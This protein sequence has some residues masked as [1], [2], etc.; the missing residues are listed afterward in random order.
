MPRRLVAV[1]VGSTHIRLVQVRGD[2]VERWASA[3][4][5]RSTAVDGAL[6]LDL[7]QQVRRLMRTSRIR[8]A[9][10]L[11]SLGGRFSL[12]RTLHLPPQP[13]NET[14]RALP[15][16]AQEAIPGDDLA[17]RWHVMT[18]DET[19]QQ[20]LV[21]GTPT[22]AVEAQASSLRAARLR[23][24]AFE[25]RAMALTRLVNQPRAI[26][27]NAEPGN[28]DMVV[29][30]QGV[31]HIMRTVPLRLDLSLQQAA[32][33]VAASVDRTVAYFND[34][35]GGSPLP[36]TT[37][38]YLVGPLAENQELRE[39]VYGMVG[40]RRAEISTPLRCPPHLPASSYAVALG[41][42]LRPL[43]SQ[44]SSS[45]GARPLSMNF[46]PAST[47]LWR[48]TPQRALVVLLVL[49]GL[50]VGNLLYGQVAR[51]NEEAAAINRQLTQVQ[52]QVT[53]RRAELNRI[54]EVEARIADFQKISEPWGQITA[55]VAL[56]DGLRQPGVTVKGYTI[57]RGQLQITANAVTIDQAITFVEALR[58]AG[59]QAPYPRV[60][61]EISATY[62]GALPK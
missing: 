4:L 29:V 44:G 3:E 6:P 50:A 24:G 55:A 38:L 37:P 35:Q 17:L 58:A 7:G 43:T 59:W 2:R 18:S 54:E 32:E 14:L 5:G 47:S 62:T 27:V 36:L 33:E 61:T 46:L 34:R 52:Q 28:L 25:L 13:L 23:P 60:A 40:F 22:S 16:L 11:V 21:L 30:H 49:A 53:L 48:F 10:L 42:A 57:T 26:I 51:V 39:Q 15:Q 12:A 56:V 31:P 1:D 19:G 20:V 41:L 9:E 8:G 45:E